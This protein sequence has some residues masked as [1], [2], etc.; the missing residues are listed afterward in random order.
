[1]TDSRHHGTSPE[2]IGRLLGG[3]PRTVRLERRALR[4]GLEAASI[5]RVTARYEDARGRGRLATFV[6]KRLAG[7]ATR[8]ARVYERLLASYAGDISPRVYTVERPAKGHA[9][10]YLEAVRGLRAWPW[11]ARSAAE[12]VLQRVAAMH[13]RAVDSAARD[14]LQDWD[15]DAELQAAAAPTLERLERVRRRGEPDAVRSAARARRLVGALPALRRE[16]LG[17]RPL[18]TAVIH[19]DLHPGN[20][21]L[22]RR[23]GRADPVLLDWGRARIGSPLEDVSSWLQSLGAWEPEARRRHDTLL[24]GYLAARGVSSR[25]TGELRAVYWLA[26]ASNAL[27]G[28]LAY[29]LAM[30]LDDRPSSRARARAGYLARE[31]TRVIRRAAAFWC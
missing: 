24:A 31:W 18:G 30:L 17:F 2:L 12:S 11:Q 27:A 13:A 7:P 23:R 26:G 1:M 21:V 29:H 5:E 14:A 4:G 20:V 22:R 16:L 9:V 25:I 19:G 15:Y 28:A 3:G 6:V 8:E 10:L